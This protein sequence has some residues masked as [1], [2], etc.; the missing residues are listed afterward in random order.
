MRD[1]PSLAIVQ[2]LE[3][4]GVAVRAY[5]PE[6]MEHARRLMPNVTFCRGP[7][8]AAEGCDAVVLVTEWDVL[9]ALDLVRIARSMRTPI[10]VDLRNIYPP[11]EVADAG[12]IGHGV[13]RPGVRRRNR[14]PTGSLA[15]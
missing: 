14:S 2:A 15:S 5:D 4:A 8:E 7:Y 12:L 13:G 3:D 1:A 10:L 11:Q 6:G 9:R